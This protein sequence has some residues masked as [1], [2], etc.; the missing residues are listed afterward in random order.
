MYAWPIAAAVLGRGLDGDRDP[1]P[2]LPGRGWCGPGAQIEGLLCVALPVPAHE[3]EPAH[4][5]IP[6]ER[7]FRTATKN[8]GKCGAPGSLT[9]RPRGSSCERR[10]L[11]SSRFG[12]RS[13]AWRI[14]FG[15]NQAHDQGDQGNDRDVQHDEPR[16]PPQ[17]YVRMSG[18][19]PLLRRLVDDEIYGRD[20]RPGCEHVAKNRPPNFDRAS[21]AP[22]TGSPR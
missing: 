21:P 10:K 11:D 19:A 6:T 4:E 14:P 12:G 18:E 5:T 8:V 7:L 15:K 13:T 9:A 2:R 20:L 1:F 17:Q 3:V 22:T 16:P